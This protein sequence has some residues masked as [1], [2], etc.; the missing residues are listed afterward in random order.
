M[1][2]QWTYIYAKLDSLLFLP[3]FTAIWFMLSILIARRRLCFRYVP[4]PLFAD[5]LFLEEDP[6]KVAYQAG[7]R[8]PMAAFPSGSSL[9]DVLGTNGAHD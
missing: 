3:F 6:I 4:L 5:F 1:H 8:G 7:G 9:G 2:A